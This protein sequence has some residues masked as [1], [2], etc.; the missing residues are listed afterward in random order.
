MYQFLENEVRKFP[1]KEKLFL[2]KSKYGK[3]YF[4]NS[5]KEKIMEVKFFDNIV[6]LKFF[7]QP[8][9]IILYLISGLHYFVKK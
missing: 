6:K 4:V 9:D 1:N 3:T 7:Q 5:K 2:V 8:S